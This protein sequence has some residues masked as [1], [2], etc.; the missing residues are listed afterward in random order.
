MMTFLEFMQESSLNR[1]RQK[2]KKGGMAIM[3][4][5][6][7]DKTKKQNAARS[8]QLDKDIRGA[9]LPGATK[10]S[11][12]YTE[13]PG[14]KDEKKVGERSHVVS[15]G[16]MGK[17]RF[18]KAITKLGKKYNQDSVLVKKK[19]KG[20]AALVG[21]NKS[22]YPGMGK[23]DKVGKMNP[24]KTGEFDTKIKKKTFTYE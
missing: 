1:I 14:T 4:A 9:G 6:R 19:P 8:K 20:D 13:N 12:R 15:S 5:Q 3:S 7:G 23:S 21:T 18:K 16:K 17:K 2:D 10:V 22:S 11:G 24:G